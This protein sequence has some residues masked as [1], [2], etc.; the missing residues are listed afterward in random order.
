[1]Q[2]YL[3]TVL[4]E[5]KIIESVFKVHVPVLMPNIPANTNTTKYTIKNDRLLTKSVVSNSTLITRNYIEAT[6]ITDYNSRIDGANVFEME[7]ADGV[8]GVETGNVAESTNA[9]ADF[10]ATDTYSPVPIACYV[11]GA[12]HANH[13]HRILGA[14]KFY[15]MKI[16]NINNIDITVGTKCLV[17]KIGSKFFITRFMGVIPQDK[18]DY[19][20]E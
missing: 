5:G 18:E 15:K 9:S 19:D 11:T 20:Y 16:T 6:T 10:K 4:N 3:G 8:T 13:V 1:M 14:F 12:P 2:V 7:R 17:V